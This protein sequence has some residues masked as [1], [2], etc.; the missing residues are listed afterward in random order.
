MRPSR[1]ELKLAFFPMIRG[2]IVG[3]L[4]ALIPGT[5]P[6][7]A[8][9][10]AY[11]TEKKIS[12]TPERFGYGAL[13]GVACPEASTHSSVQGDFI[14]TMSL[15]IPGDAVMALLLG[16]LTIQGIVPGPQLIS[17]HPDIF[18]GLVASFW[19][20]NILLVILNVPLIGVWVKLLAIPYR[21]LYPSALFFVCIGVY[22]A[23][24]D[25]FQVGET[26]VIGIFGY[27]LLRLGFHPAPILLGFV[28]GPRFEENFR[29]AM[30]ISRGDIWVFVERP[31]SAVF[32]GLCFVLIA[33]QIYFRLRG[34][35]NA[36][37]TV[38][39]M[40]G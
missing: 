6:T 11:A 18:W 19:I 25:M 28:L 4:C 39:V 36:L 8:S 24:N 2:T 31:I 1:A 29:R 23:N 35:K 32:V 16:A 14:P 5:G 34:P 10:V 3:S 15:G 26:I 27:V 13:E 40:H 17:Q 33:A 38:P 20:G 30:L 7:I 22:A 37:P 9:F 21:F 12:K